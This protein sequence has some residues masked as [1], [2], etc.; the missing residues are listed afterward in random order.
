MNKTTSHK[1]GFT[2]AGVL[3]LIVTSAHADTFG[4]G[5]NIFNIDFVTIG[6]AGNPLDTGTTGLY[7]S[8]YGAGGYEFQMGT[9]EIGEDT[10]DKANTV[11]GLFITKTTRSANQA[12]TA[13][14]VLLMRPRTACPRIARSAVAAGP[15]PRASCA[16]RA[17]ASARRRPRTPTWVS[18]WRASLNPPSRC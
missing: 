11:G 2:L 15:T 17:G 8:P 1:L 7:S 18:V 16:P 6:D 13:V 14:K 4:S 12:A 5:A 3:A 10:I 9:Y